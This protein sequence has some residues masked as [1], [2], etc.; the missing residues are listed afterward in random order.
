VAGSSLKPL[1]LRLHP[2]SPE[3]A[4]RY[5]PVSVGVMDLHGRIFNH[6]RHLLFQGYSLDGFT[7][8]LLLAGHDEYAVHFAI[9]CA[10]QSYMRLAGLTPKE[11]A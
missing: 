5:F 4:Q 3:Y 10:E 6:G 9:E 8:G 2:A 11:Y 7:K 1:P